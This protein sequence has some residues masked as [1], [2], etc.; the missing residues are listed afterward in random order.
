MLKQKYPE[1]IM[2]LLG[3][4]WN[5]DSHTSTGSTVTAKA[6]EDIYEKLK[7]WEKRGYLSIIKGLEVHDDFLL[8]EIKK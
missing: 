8:F 7:D 5:A 4:E 1:E 3:L 2:K 6:W